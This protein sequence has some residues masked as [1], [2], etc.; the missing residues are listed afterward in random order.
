MSVEV[1]KEIAGKSKRSPKKISRINF[2][3]QNQSVQKRMQTLQDAVQSYLMMTD[4]FRQNVFCFFDFFCYNN[5]ACLIA[6]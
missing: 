3:G 6:I 5:F 1:S 2:L 4:A